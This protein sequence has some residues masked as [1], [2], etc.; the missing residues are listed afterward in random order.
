M[1]RTPRSASTRDGG[2]RVAAPVVD[3][4]EHEHDDLQ[5]GV[6]VGRRATAGSLPRY[7]RQRFTLARGSQ[8]IV[9]RGDEVLDSLFEWLVRELRAQVRMGL[10]ALAPLGCSARRSCLVVLPAHSHRVCIPISAG[11]RS[12][13]AAGVLP[14]FAARTF[15]PSCA[16]D[17]VSERLRA[18]PQSGAHA[19]VDVFA[20]ERTRHVR[21][22]QAHRL[23]SPW[24]H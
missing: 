5:C 19:S 20:S 21:A 8:D 18:R 9:R 14:A 2:P 13:C 3:R 22:I 4:P 1:P 17:L 15:A 11:R 23:P 7:V 16:A 6:E 24:R 12:V 10:L